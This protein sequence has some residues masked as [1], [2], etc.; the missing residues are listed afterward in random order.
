M[1][2]S[3]GSVD[4]EKGVRWELVAEGNYVNSDTIPRYRGGLD[5]GLPL[6]PAHSTLWLLN[7]AGVAD[8]DRADPFASFF[9]GGFGNNY[10]DD[11][12]VKRY[13][14]H[15]AMPGFE[16]NALGLGTRTFAK[17]TLEWN[18]PPAVF[19]RV[20]TPGFYLAWARP[21][22]FVTELV[23]DFDNAPTRVEA[24]SAGLQIDLRFQVLHR[25]DMTLSAGYAA[26]FLDS[27]RVDDEVMVSLKIL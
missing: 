1:H 9:F 16:L 17:S 24:Q 22:V 6:G 3:L 13:R 27:E 15:Y 14:K 11:G 19:D 18:L 23:M 5:F 26:G 25:L 4:D 8:G 12:E 2:N 21:S 20:G 7:A 10:V